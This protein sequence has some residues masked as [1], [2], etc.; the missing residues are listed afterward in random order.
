M[1]PLITLCLIL[2]FPSVAVGQ[3]RPK[4]LQVVQQA[5][6]T[7]ELPTTPINIACQADPTTVLTSSLTCAAF[8]LDMQGY[9]RVWLLIEYTF[10]AATTIEVAQD[11]ALGTDD[12]K[13]AVTPWGIVQRPVDAG[14]GQVDLFNEFASKG[15]SASTSMI[16]EYTTNSPFVRWRYTTTGPATSGD[17]VRVFL[18]RRGP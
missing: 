18:V 4:N 11:G 10:G 13:T 1:R 12:G 5:R 6:L 8:E 16:V 15:V 17:T 14:S 3:L 2:L 9:T 7:P